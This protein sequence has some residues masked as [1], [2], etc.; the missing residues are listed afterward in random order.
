MEIAKPK[1][2]FSA[3]L[4]IGGQAK[5]AALISKMKVAP[6]R[7]WI[8]HFF[9]L[10]NELLS[11]TGLTSDDPSLVMSICSN[12]SKIPITINQRYV[13]SALESGK[14]LLGFILGAEYSRFSRLQSSAAV[15][16]RFG[17]LR[18]ESPQSDPPYYLSF[19]DVPKEADFKANWREAVFN[20]LKRGKASSFRKYHE[21]IVYEAAMDLAYRKYLLD[22]AFP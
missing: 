7:E 22:K 10:A 12:T 18:G 9:D 2:A 15:E 1:P 16:W 19:Y 11:F 14:P 17:Y 8:D 3:N 4:L 21:Q 13:L 5:E 20:E 6:N